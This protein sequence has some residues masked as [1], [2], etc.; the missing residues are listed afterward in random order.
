[1]TQLPS[2]RW[3]A[4]RPQH[5]KAIAHQRGLTLVELMVAMAISLV[6]ALAAVA[7]LTMAR[8]GFTT[9]DAASQL[10]DNA[11]FSTDI[12][13]RLG[14]QAGYQDVGWAITERKKEAGVSTNPDPFVSGLNNAKRNAQSDLADVGVA[15]TAG[16]PGYGSDILIFRYQ[17]S[18]TFPGSRV[19][20]NTMINCAGSNATG[21]AAV[22]INRDD[23]MVSILHVQESNG[24]LSL[25]CSTSANGL[26]PY[27][28]VQP[29]VQGVENFQVLYG[30]D[31]STATEPLR[32]DRFFRAD[33]MVVAGD[34]LATNNNWRRVR[35]I[36]IGMVIRGPA[37]SSQDMNTQTFYP[38]GPG[39]ASAAG[40][41]GSAFS[42][43][44]DPG[45]VFTPTID[46]R[47]R[48]VVTFTIHMRN[49]QD[50]CATASGTTPI[51]S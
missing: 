16:T 36:R 4:F 42:S 21:T 28:I 49:F 1:M 45:T 8:R 5:A 12:L 40:A 3:H 44:S 18:E 13:Q 24:E 30:V 33:E 46:G 15:R 34:P 51:C 22:P 10:R 2:P 29:L 23:R 7:A 19:A 31:G 20:D 14:V 9:V 50:Q 43:S 25:M 41:V 6:I 37:N 38:F 39:K 35:S 47:L 17:A 11:R 26:T 32:A 48:Q 27:D